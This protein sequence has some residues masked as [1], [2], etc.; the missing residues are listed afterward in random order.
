M[1]KKQ[2]YVPQFYLK[3]FSNNSKSIGT[4]IASQDKIIWYA[5]IAHMAYKDNLYGADNIIENELCKFELKWSI[6]IKRIIESNKIDCLDDFMTILGF[7]TIGNARTLKMAEEQ[8]YVED[9]LFKLNMQNFIP[10]KQLDTVKI[11]MDFPISCA[12]KVAAESTML[13]TDLKPIILENKSK[14]LFITS[15]NPICLYNKL[16]VER[17]YMRNYGFGSGGL[18]IILPLTPYK[19]FCLYDSMVYKCS[20][21]NLITITSNSQIT[22]LNKLFVR[23]SYYNIFFNN[24]QEEYHIK[25]I[26]KSYKKINIEKCIS[27]VGPIIQVGANSILERFRLDF[28]EVKQEYKTIKLP[29]H[30]AGL[31]RPSVECI[32]NELQEANAINQACKDSVE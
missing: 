19:C 25:S 1:G 31:V 15:D 22:E 20:H 11:G 26:K 7:I 32:E 9:Y 30:L 21:D 12:L 14:T 10:K 4:W 28:L 6:V 8:S 29:S 18:I 5:S 3:F 16:Y 24:D 23:N 17:C 13:L 27:R 2:H